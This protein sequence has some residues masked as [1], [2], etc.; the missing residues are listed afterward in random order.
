MEYFSH[1]IPHLRQQ[2]RVAPTLKRRPAYASHDQLVC[3]A[4]LALRSQADKVAGCTDVLDLI[5]SLIYRVKLLDV[6]LVHH[7]LKAKRLM[8]RPATH[9]VYLRGFY[10]NQ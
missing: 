9:P 7:C 10:R 8:G 1:R 5:N 2:N 3:E 4:L 6:S